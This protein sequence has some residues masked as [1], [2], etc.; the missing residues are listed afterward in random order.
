MK[1]SCITT[2]ILIAIG[3]LPIWINGQKLEQQQQQ[4]RRKLS[5]DTLDADIE[6]LRRRY[7][8]PSVGGAIVTLD[9]EDDTPFYIHTTG[10]RRR[11]PRLLEWPWRRVPV[12]NDDLWH[13]GSCGKAMTST[14]FGRLYEQGIV[15][16]WNL[17]LQE[18]FADIDM[19]GLQ[20]ADITITQLLTHTSGL[21]RR[22]PFLD[23]YYQCDDV[24]EGRRRMLEQAL[25]INLLFDP[26]TSFEYSNLGYT[27]AGAVAEQLT[28]QSWEA[29]MEEYV[30]DP[31]G[32]DSGGFGPTGVP[33]EVDQPWPHRGS[34]IPLITDG[35]RADLPAVYGP[36][37]LVHS[38]LSD[39][40][41]F[42]RVHMNDAAQPDFLSSS[43]LEQL[44]TPINNDYAYGWIVV[45]RDWGGDG[46]LYFHDGTNGDNYSIVWVAPSAGFAILMVT[47]Q[48]TSFRAL[49]E[50]AGML[51][52]AWLSS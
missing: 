14:L 18:V 43:T 38:S 28:G 47:N 44:H 16:S 50:L 22:A 27:L 4:Q 6:A 31:L 49:D 20:H 36:A 17:T 41:K 29:L 1:I 48:G 19:T 5:L 46:P 51:I 11:W 23:L 12:T 21:V 10:Y 7:R 34:G 24:M 35:L 26:G 25:S 13:L 40:A 3:A 52:N 2:T 9:D 45:E 39:W 42:I 30:F 37:G 32:M 33:G 8:L 15:S